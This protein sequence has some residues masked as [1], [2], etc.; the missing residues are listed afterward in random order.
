MERSRFLDEEEINLI[1]LFKILILTPSLKDTALGMKDEIIIKVNDT[2]PENS[3]KKKILKLLEDYISPDNRYFNETFDA[4]EENKEALSND[5]D[6]MTDP[7]SYF[8]FS[9]ILMKYKDIINPLLSFLKE[10]PDF[11]EVLYFIEADNDIDKDEDLVI[12]ENLIIFFKEYVDIIDIIP[13]ILSDYNLDENKINYT[14]FY[15]NLIKY[16]EN[17]ANF[18][19]DL[20]GLFANNRNLSKILNKTIDKVSNVNTIKKI[21]TFIY[22]HPDKV[23]EL[24][25]ICK[26]DTE[27]LTAI[28]KLIENVPHKSKLIYLLF[29]NETILKHPDLIGII[30]S[31]GLSFIQSGDTAGNFVDLLSQLVQGAVSAFIHNNKEK[32]ENEISEKCRK[33]VNYTILSQDFDGNDELSANVSKFFLYKAIIDTTKSSNDL[34]TYDN[35]LKKPPILEDLN[36]D[37]MEK[38][39]AVPAFILA[40]MDN[41]AGENKNKYKTS[42][43]IEDTYNVVSLCLPKGINKGRNSGIYL[44]CNDNEYSKII[45]YVFNL[46]SDTSETEIR[47]I[48]IKKGTEIRA[49]SIKKGQLKT[50]KNSGWIIAFG[51]LIPF[52]IIL[53][54]F[55]LYFILLACK[56]NAKKKNT[57]NNE[58][59]A[60]DNSQSNTN[61]EQI[62]PVIER[63]NNPRWII[64]LNEFFNFNDNGKELFNFENKDTNINNINGLKYIG[65]LMGISIV[66]TILGQIYLILYNLPMKDFG[67]AN[68]YSLFKSFFYIF[69]FIG[70]RYSPRIIFSCS[71]FTLSFKYIAFIDKESKNYCLKFILRHFFKY[72]IL[73]LILLF[74]RHSYYHFSTLLFD[75]QPIYELF[76][77]NVLMVPEE[78]SNFILSLLLFKSFQF[79]KID[80]R[81]RHYLIDYF[82]MPINEIIFFIF[83]TILITIGYKCKLRIDYAIIIIVILLYI[84]KIIFYYAYFHLK[85]NIY[86]TLYYYIFDYGQ[87]MLNPIFN[88]SYYLIGMYF[89]LINYNLE[90]GITLTKENMYKLIHEDND[91]DNDKDEDNEDINE[92]NR[93]ITS[94]NESYL[95]LE[96]IDN[97]NM[98][99]I[100]NKSDIS[101]GTHKKHRK[102]LKEKNKIKN[103]LI[104]RNKDINDNNIINNEIS[105]E[106]KTMPFLEGPII[107]KDWHDKTDLKCFY[108]L[109]FFLSLI[110]IFFIC[111]HYMFIDYYRKS[112]NNNK[113]YNEMQKKLI[114]LSLKNIITNK[115]LN[116]IYLV[117][118]ELVVLFVQWGFFILLIKQQFIIEFFNHIYWTFFNK[119]YFSFLLS[120]NSSILYIFYQ[121]ETVVKLNAFNLWLYFFISTVF[122]FLV[123]F[124]I[125]IAFEL[126]LKKI[127]KYLLSNDYKIDFGEQYINKVDN[128][129]DNMFDNDSD[130]ED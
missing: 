91:L 30:V 5:L 1:Q 31:L 14:N 70:L 118:I 89:G 71:G 87:M 68:F 9:I 110:I 55:I 51:K 123:T 120:C 57:N 35:C 112:I 46:F 11:L 36:I 98:N 18:T 113:D 44:D 65:G 126:P 40:T 58:S 41:S 127:T 3:H 103:P 50:E 80:S 7:N 124:L 39:G 4:I 94:H 21:F 111:S 54:P 105:P 108:F 52:Y 95:Q 129:K 85:E 63:R 66:L 8:E 62:E 2:I 130:D 20:I 96:D 49:I 77:Q 72:L 23:E 28:P 100:L 33:F 82:W 101:M 117:D 16:A 26:N 92:I 74:A 32:I 122:I 45:G 12:K 10:N 13:N 107:I 90:K 114:I 115:L 24:Y 104:N 99:D 64:Y 15:I 79:N 42:T 59:M 121:S 47:A 73:I 83:G 116:F 6:H 60:S 29:T 119:F 25:A 93:K 19:L 109:L 69:F 37:D 125:Y 84:G 88:L 56:S 53:L 75:I 38:N 128:K 97:N 61:K 86:T 27:V 81:V 43:L 17:K 78:S 102:F 76:N 67:P 34:L 48:S 22:E 106:I